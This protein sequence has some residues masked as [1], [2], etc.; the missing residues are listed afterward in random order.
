MLELQMGIT[1]HGYFMLIILKRLL[2]L[3]CNSV[4]EHFPTLTKVLGSILSI[5]ILYVIW[6]QLPF[7]FFKLSLYFIFS[8]FIISF[9]HLLTCVYIVCAFSLPPPSPPFPAYMSDQEKITKKFF[10]KK[11][12]NIH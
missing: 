3:E 5:K 6:Q 11:S 10:L 9:L 1:T 2:G 4:A 12:E 8:T 7:F